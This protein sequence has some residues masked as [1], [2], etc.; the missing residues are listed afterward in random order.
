MS[1]TTINHNKRYVRVST[2][3]HC[4]KD[5][6]INVLVSDGDPDGPIY[7]PNRL[8]L[9]MSRENAEILRDALTEALEETKPALTKEE[10]IQAILD[11]PYS[12]HTLRARIRNILNEGN[13]PL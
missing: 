1:S 4:P 13:V 11:G 5:Q 7:M 8:G 9:S 6:P 2:F 3:G 12:P 10:R